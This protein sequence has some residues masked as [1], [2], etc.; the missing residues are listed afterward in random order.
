MRIVDLRLGLIAV[1]AW[2]MPGCMAPEQRIVGHLP[3]PLFYKPIAP[4][5]TRAAVVSVPPLKVT[6]AVPA[7]TLTL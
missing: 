6:V 4:A 7:L 3:D 2:G 5:P 1:A